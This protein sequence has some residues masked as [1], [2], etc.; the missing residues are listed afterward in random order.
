MKIY[1]RFSRAQQV[2]T[3]TSLF[4]YIIDI[5]L[6]I[7]GIVLRSML[8]LHR[9]WH[10]KVDQPEQYQWITELTGEDVSKMHSLRLK[11]NDPE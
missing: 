5:F 11:D 3:F 9:L 7:V 10:G 4:L 6:D 8:K 1:S 2:C